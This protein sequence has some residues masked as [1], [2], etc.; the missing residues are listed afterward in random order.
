MPEELKIIWLLA[1]AFGVACIAAYCSQRI[2][3]SPI[4]GYLLAGY[5][6][7]PNSP[8]Y[9]LSQ[10][11]SDQLAIIGVTLLMFIVGLNF[12]WQDIFEDKRLVIPGALILSAFSILAGLILSMQLGETAKAGFVVGLAICVSSTVVMVRVL[13][14]QNLLHTQQGKIVIGWTILEDLVSVF[15][16]ILLPVLALPESTGTHPFV[17]LSYSIAIVCVKIALLGVIV[18][19]IGGKLIEKTLKIIARTK[20]H[21]LFTLA[22][23]AWT[24]AI[25][26]GCS[27]FFGVS[28]ALGAF[29]AGTVV[30]ETELSHQ[31]AANALPMRD[32]F[33]VIFFLSVGM[34]FNP[35]VVME[36]FSLFIGIFVIV[37]ILR[38]LLAFW[39]TKISK[40]PLYV[41]FTVAV[42]ISQI[43]E[44]SFILA[45]EG[46]RL[47]ILPDAAYDIIVACAFITIALNPIL[48]QLF[49]PLTI[50]KGLSRV[51]EISDL[52]ANAFFE[53]RDSTQ[54]FLPKAIVIG[55]GHVGKRLSRYLRND[56]QVL[57]I[58][59]NIDTVCSGKGKNIEIL[60]GDATQL[61]LLERANVENA[62]LIAITTTNITVTRSI[63]DATQ[64]INPEA[65]IIAR[66]HYKDDYTSVQFGDIPI[67]CDEDASSEK[68]IAEI[69]K[70]KKN[71]L[72]KDVG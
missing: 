28:L 3:L 53:V 24:F 21:E 4:F 67:I 69:K 12:H 33:A 42:A 13:A 49:K 5:L 14:D 57:V 15:G 62:Q 68:M 70:K 65:E 43:G 63:I 20:S 51:Q 50:Q 19:F 55:Y 44:Y 1:I 8:G 60:Y 48:F 34:L 9:I 46:S 22:I 52:A 32:A 17:T 71:T 26:V 10:S 64:R 45:E 61:Q 66:A 16:L 18:Y 31:A 40:Y 35:K 47:K 25:A 36:N 7:G 58:D 23:L 2:K 59:Q 72:S 6:L 30:G 27:Y 37:L 39:M 38:P 29:I 11:V 54:S 56:Y 41:G